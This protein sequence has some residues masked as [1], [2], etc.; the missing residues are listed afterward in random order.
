MNGNKDNRTKRKSAQFPIAHN[1]FEEPGGVISRPIIKS[2]VTLCFVVYSSV[3]YGVCNV[4]QV[5]VVRV[6]Y[7]SYIRKIHVLRGTF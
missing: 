2:N 7:W 1:R 3:T 5:V 6:A 4:R